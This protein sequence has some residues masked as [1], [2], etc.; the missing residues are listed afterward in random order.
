MYVADAATDV[1]NCASAYDLPG[2]DYGPS[3]IDWLYCEDD[4]A[5]VY[6]A[7]L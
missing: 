1:P 5:A 2:C 6:V 4:D 3:C 7:A